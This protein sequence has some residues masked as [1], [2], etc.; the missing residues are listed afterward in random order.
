[1]RLEFGGGA[2]G[3]LGGWLRPRPCIRHQR[4]LHHH[5]SP[6]LQL[7][8]CRQHRIRGALV[9]FVG[10]F[11]DTLALRAPNLLGGRID[12]ERRR[13]RRRSRRI[14]LR[15]RFRIHHIDRLAAAVVQ[16][17]E[18]EVRD[19]GFDVDDDAGE[20][21]EADWVVEEIECLIGVGGDGARSWCGRRNRLSG[22]NR[23]L[24]VVG[25]VAITLVGAK[26]LQ[27]RPWTEDVMDVVGGQFD[28][29]VPCWG[30]G[31]AVGW[32]EGQCLLWWWSCRWDVGAF[33]ICGC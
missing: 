13:T 30:G 20:L 18:P 11:I 12:R 19:V 1:M 17:E 14:R 24:I 33:G 15:L 28:P 4:P 23:V 22:S 10:R 21:H 9:C 16:R 26:D 8:H 29:D 27:S 6:H 2:D 32:V 3:G 25:I 7:L 5:H 31:V